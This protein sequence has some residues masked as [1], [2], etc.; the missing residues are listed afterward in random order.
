LEHWG[1]SPTGTYQIHEL[2]TDE[3]YLWAGTRNFVEL[4]PLF[5]PAHVFRLRRHVRT[6]QDFDYFL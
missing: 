3:R 2:L 4:N 5:V 6:E 1:L